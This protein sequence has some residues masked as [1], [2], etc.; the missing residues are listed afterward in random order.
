MLIKVLSTILTNVTMFYHARY[1]LMVVT[2]TY[3]L[4]LSISCK[5]RFWITISI[6]D[7]KH[8]DTFSLSD[9]CIRA[10]FKI[11]SN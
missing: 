2:S 11:N 1:R 8:S 6:M 3:C 7:Y 4:I 9:I 5:I 10:A